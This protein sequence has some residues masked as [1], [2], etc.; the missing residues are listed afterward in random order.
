MGAE[1]GTATP[2]TQEADLSAVLNSL[3]VAV[4]KV[5]TVL[6]PVFMGRKER[7]HFPTKPGHYSKNSLKSSKTFKPG[8]HTPTKT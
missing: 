3:N 2:G 5:T 4:E 6:K 7:S 1:T 8:V